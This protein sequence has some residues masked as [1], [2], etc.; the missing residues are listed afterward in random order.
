[1]S[2]T[3]EHKMMLDGIR[4]SIREIT[5][6]LIDWAENAMDHHGPDAV[7]PDPI[8]LAVHLRI[9]TDLARD[10]A[11]ARDHLASLMAPVVRANPSTFREPLPGIGLLKVGA[12][13]TRHD[14]DDAA[15][16]SRLA[17]AVTHNAD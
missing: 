7:N 6:E 1:M 3:P 12:D 5:D 9:L 2:F 14:Y 10:A 11:Q 16:A 17:R 8:A 4:Y 15:L 13:T